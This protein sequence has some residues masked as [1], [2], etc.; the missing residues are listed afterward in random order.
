VKLL[1][2]FVYSAQCRVSLLLVSVQCTV[3]GE[4]VIGVFVYSEQCTVHSESVMCGC[5][6]NS[7]ERDCFWGVYRAQCIVRL[8]LVC[9]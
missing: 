7:A 5:T 4:T 6:V 3:Q 8:L 1:L 2:V 9:V